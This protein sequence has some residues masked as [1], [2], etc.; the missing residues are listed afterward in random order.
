VDLGPAARF[1]RISAAPGA[2]TTWTLRATDWA[3]NTTSA[4]VTRTPLLAADGSAARTGSWRT[5]R[6]AA[7]LGS[8]ALTSSTAGS[9]MTYTFTGRG[10]A[11]VASRTSGSGRVR[12]YLDSADRGLLD[13]RSATTAHRMSVWAGNYSADGTHTLKVQVE[14]TAGRP[15]VIMDGI[16][17]LS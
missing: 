3:G 4:S 12:V 2:A 10:V 17:V 13:L 9:S 7:Y 11:L 15:G 16:A 5:L 6:N 1:A 14:G 8:R